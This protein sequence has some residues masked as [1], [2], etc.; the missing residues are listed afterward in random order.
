ME[1]F[2]IFAQHF[3]LNNNKWHTKQQQNISSTSL[4]LSSGQSVDRIEQYRVHQ[5]KYNRHYRKYEVVVQ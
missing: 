1:N 3:L 5:P 4:A 2:E